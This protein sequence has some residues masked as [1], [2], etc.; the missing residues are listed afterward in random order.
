MSVVAVCLGLK[1]ASLARCHAAQALRLARGW[2]ALHV[3]TLTREQ[4][5]C[6]THV[7]PRVF[8]AEKLLHNVQVLS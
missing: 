2:R 3:T 7:N 5:Y 6:V 8:D 4:I 1:A